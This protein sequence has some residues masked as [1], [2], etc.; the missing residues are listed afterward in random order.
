MYVIASITIIVI[1]LLM[2]YYYTN[3]YSE[4]Y[5]IVY[6]WVD[7]NDKE[8]DS[9]IKNV[10]LLDDNVSVYR[11]NNADELL[12]SIKSV[13]LYCKNVN[14]IF[15]VVKDGH[16]PHL[17]F[18]DPSIQI[19][20]HSDIMP[21]SALPSFNSCAI[22]LCIHKIPRLLDRY[23]YFN[24]DMFVNYRVDWNMLFSNNRMPKVNV[25]YNSNNSI[26]Y[27]HFY[28]F[29]AMYDNTIKFANNIL[30]TDLHIKLPH[31]PSVCYKPW[32]YEIETI[33]KT[34]NVW[35]ET[36]HSKFRDNNNI[37]LN[38]GFRTVYYIFKGS[39]I[40][41]WGDTYISLSENCKLDRGNDLFFCVNNISD[42]CKDEFKKQLDIYYKN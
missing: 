7:E 37:I 4:P 42:K 24:D 3:L 19:V 39:E 10:D 9:Y 22:E 18:S 5:D 27:T 21:Q 40:A 2:Y 32:E 23:L 1:I 28:N 20:L 8:R 35:D 26:T 12:Y 41:D 36:L 6:T 15:I 25:V 17:N 16:I 38:N 11:Y 14:K 34:S 30:G 33:L 29:F 31:T 13:K